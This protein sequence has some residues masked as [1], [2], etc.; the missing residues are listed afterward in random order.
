MNHQI[1][2]K[3]CIEGAKEIWDNSVDLII[4]DPPFGIEEGS[5]SKHYYRDNDKVINGYVQAPD[6]YYEFSYAWIEQ[7][8]RILKDNGSMFIV[9]GWSNLRHIENAIASHGMHMVN[10]MIWKF[11]FGVFTRKKMV[12][13]HYHIL[14][15]VKTKKAKPV[16]NTYCRFG[17]DE[18]TP[19]GRSLLYNDMEDVW[20]INKEYN[21]G[22]FK[23]INKLPEELIRK[24]IQYYS[25]ERDLVCDFFMGNFTTAS[26]ALKMG[27]MVCGFELNENS[28]NHFMPIIN[29]IEFGSDLKLLKKVEVNTPKNQGKKLTKEEIELI[30]NDFSE[31]L[32][33]NTK[34]KSLIILSEKHGRGR[35]S[36]ERII[37]R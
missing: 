29:K 25:N 19:D 8:K 5:F 32:K 37:K 17:F 27:R 21:S 24:I 35:W 11:N 2:N 7:C 3:D 10:H 34:A 15:I 20:T 18:K 1:F 33:T 28:Y 30:K 36:L 16:F 13:S 4:C 31:L 23:S 9:S 22:E 6:D 12:S 26:V 14:Y